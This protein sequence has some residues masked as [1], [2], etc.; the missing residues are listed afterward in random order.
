MYFIWPLLL[1]VL[2]FQTI[3][4]YETMFFTNKPWELSC[5]V[6]SSLCHIPLVGTVAL[7]CQTQQTQTGSNL[8][9]P[10]EHK[11]KTSLKYSSVHLNSEIQILQAEL[12][13]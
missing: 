10:A 6:W 9:S 12:L 1:S 7:Y 4:G 13:D 8:R 3:H 5:P 11:T 2:K